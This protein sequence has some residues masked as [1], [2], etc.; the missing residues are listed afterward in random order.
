VIDLQEDSVIKLKSES[1]L[2]LM[3]RFCYKCGALEG[4][5][6]PLIQGLCQR[7]FSDLQLLH[8]PSELDVV[9]C[10]R[11][12]AYKLGKQWRGQISGESFEGVIREAVLNTIKLSRCTDSGTKLLRPAETEDVYVEVM[13]STKKNFVKV[14]ASGK[15][16]PLQI[17]PKVD[18]ATM[19]LNLIYSTC[20]VCSLKSA[21]HHD[22]ILQL[23]GALSQELLSRAQRAV[24]NLATSAAKQESKDF[25]ADVKEQH[26]GLDFYVSSVALAKRMAALLKE[27]FNANIVES[28]K[29]I[30]Q[31]QDGRKKYR[32]SILARLKK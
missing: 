1:E 8:A 21:K 7:C 17:R 18:E 16:H 6:G 28:A 30:G 20:E 27:K 15:S 25:I 24:E 23:R 19:K 12:G 26:G 3:R 31:T 32:V 29:L 11:C 14:R 10:K 5:T 9:V 22:A 13:S 2:I 4:E